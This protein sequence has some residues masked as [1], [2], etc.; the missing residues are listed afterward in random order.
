MDALNAYSKSIDEQRVAGLALAQQYKDDIAQIMQ[1]SNERIEA[2][3]KRWA[4]RMNELSNAIVSSE[5]VRQELEESFAQERAKYL[6][7]REDEIDRFD[8]Q[9]D[10]LEKMMTN[11][12]HTTD[13]TI[14]S[15]YSSIEDIRKQMRTMNDQ[16]TI[17]LQ[18]QSQLIE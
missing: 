4:D 11:H 8:R 9:Y 5:E 18:N 10:V 17:H 13:R 7:D 1:T 3:D 15:M 12:M 2:M 6:K 16:L 14:N